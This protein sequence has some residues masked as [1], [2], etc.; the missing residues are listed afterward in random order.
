MM[1]TI[2]DKTKAECLRQKKHVIGDSVFF[3]LIKLKSNARYRILTESG[4]QASIIPIDVVNGLLEKGF[5]RYTDEGTHITLTGRGLWNVE[6]NTQ[7]KEL[8]QLVGFLD[9]EFFNLFSEAKSLTAK[10]KIILLTLLAARAFSPESAVHLKKS[11]RINNEWG[12]I[13]D[14]ASAFLEER[15]VVKKMLSEELYGKAGNEH[16]VSSC[17]RH[18]DML[19]KKTRGIFTAQGKQVYFL[20]IYRDGKT[21]PVDISFL[22]EIIFGDKLDA[23][24]MNQIYDF[25]CKI[26]SEKSIY[27]FENIDKH[28]FA[29]HDYG[30]I[31]KEAL[32]DAVFKPKR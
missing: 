29:N 31:I 14:A 13:I 10:E 11:D 24:L 16:P 15:K 4:V 32:R 9:E 27:V 1:V 7:K 8:E 17:I 21:D 18:T 19:P 23:A 26:S 30:E 6:K 20:N 2:Y 25:C 3:T 28:I 22:L 12:K 5:A